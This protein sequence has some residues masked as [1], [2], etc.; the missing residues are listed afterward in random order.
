MET[1]YSEKFLKQLEETA[2]MIMKRAGESGKMT[3]SDVAFITLYKK[4]IAKV[5]KTPIFDTALK[6]VKKL[7]DFINSNMKN[8]GK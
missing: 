8:G 3:D 6:S 4:E 2:T 7:T 5:N 1:K